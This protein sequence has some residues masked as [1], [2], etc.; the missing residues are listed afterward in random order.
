[1]ATGVNVLTTGPVLAL[2]RADLH[3]VSYTI[4]TD[5]GGGSPAKTPE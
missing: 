3:I 4:P 5:A 2:Q 1:M